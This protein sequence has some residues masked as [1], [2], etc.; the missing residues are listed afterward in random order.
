M[1]VLQCTKQRKEEGRGKEGTPDEVKGSFWSGFFIYF[2]F[3]AV[4]DLPVEPD[5][6]VALW[7]DIIRVHAQ[8]AEFPP[9]AFSLDLLERRLADEVSGL[10]GHKCKHFF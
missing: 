2:Y 8:V 7:V 5:G 9:Q 3:F 1:L 4:A 6:L 10:E